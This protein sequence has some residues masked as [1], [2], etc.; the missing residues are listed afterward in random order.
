MKSFLIALEVISLFISAVIVF[1]NFR[2][3]VIMRGGST[4]NFKVVLS[5]YYHN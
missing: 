4:L 1:I 2:T 5:Y 3:P